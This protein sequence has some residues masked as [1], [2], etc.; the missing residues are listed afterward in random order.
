MDKT[1]LTI[2]LD[3]D[4]LEKLD[5]YIDG[6][7]IRNRS[8]AIEY[9]LSKYFSPK[10]RKALILTG[11][12]ATSLPKGMIE[13]NARPV[14]EHTVENLR[15]YG[16]REIIFSLGHQGEKIRK[17]F[18]DGSRFGIKATYLEQGKFQT[19][20]AQPIMQAKTE[21]GNSPFM[22]IY[23]DVIA[24]LDLDDMM[25]F[26]LSHN[27]PVTIALTAVNRS[28]DWGVVRIQGS[29]V[30]SFLEKPDNRRDLSNIINAGVYIFDPEIFDYLKDATRLEKD[31]FPKL[32]EER[33]LFGYIFAGDWF[34]VGNSESYNRAIKEWKN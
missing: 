14:L 30:Y 22:V 31:V 20:T 6:A 13:I 32:V 1:R 15:R 18:G 2:T 3:K 27:G 7:R 10:V 23:G 8:H 16:V 9:V 24:Q 26:H 5:E 28:S 34:D 21:L 4:I 17:H 19:G 29:R 33:K 25:D 12:K 11:G